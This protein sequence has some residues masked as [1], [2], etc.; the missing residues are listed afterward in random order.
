MNRRMSWPAFLAGGLLFCGSAFGATQKLYLFNWTEYMDPDIIKAF[1]SKY[2][3]D[4]VES[5]FGSLAEM[6]AK[7]QAGGDAQYDVIVPSN[8]FV[9]RLIKAGLVQPL[10]LDKVPNMANVMDKF[11]H[12]SYDPGQAYSAPYQWG[13]TGIVYNTKAYPDAPASW[14]L[15]FDPEQTG[16]QPFSM[17]TDGQVMI[18][19]A[20]AYLGKGYQCTDRK[21]WAEAAKLLLKTKHRDNFTGFVDGTPALPQ[22]ARGVT[23]AALTFNGDYLLDKA[24]NPDGFKYLEYVL[25]EEGSELWVD[26]MMIP[27]RAP[28]PELANAFI[29][30]IL[31]AKV[32][33]QLSNYNYYSTPNKA[34]VPHLDPELQV[35]PAMPTD[36]QMAKL[37]FTP[38]LDGEAL[39]TFQQIWSEVQSR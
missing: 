24:E 8:Y 18:G 3:V 11:Q 22:M 16:G 30:F 38:S 4:V 27:K 32:G 10:E 14:S 35:P 2:D 7:L 9:P 37:Y 26:V 13:T 23:Q 28:H 39:Q 34:A 5:H 33:A 20:C 6:Y 17:M 25:P 21:S 19:A 36:E 12:P 31:D 1:E 15:I 29:N